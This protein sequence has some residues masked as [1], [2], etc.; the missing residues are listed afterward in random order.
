LLSEGAELL[1]GPATWL[2][3]A[4]YPAVYRENWSTSH[5]VISSQRI[6]KSWDRRG[7]APQ[8]QQADRTDERINNRGSPAGRKRLSRVRHTKTGS[9]AEVRDRK[10]EQ[11]GHR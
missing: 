2:L 7:K 4:A 1:G 5:L 3:G 11:K 8:V 10:A 6:L 9:E